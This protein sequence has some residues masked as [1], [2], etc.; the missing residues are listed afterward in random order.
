MPV[1]VGLWQMAG[2]LGLACLLGGLLGLERDVKGHEAGLRTH[3]LL[4]LGS[5]MFALVSVASFGDFIDADA[6]TVQVDPSRIASYVAAGVGF[7]GG[8]AILKHGGNVTGLTTAASLWVAAAIGV[9]TGLGMWPAAL[10]GAGLRTGV[11]GDPP[12]DLA[13]VRTAT[14]PPRGRLT[15]PTGVGRRRRRRRPGPPSAVG[16]GRRPAD[17]GPSLRRRVPA[18]RSAVS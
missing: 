11:V 6:S 4:S 3:M 16:V 13:C 15:R 17:R 14:D 12:S 18:G 10:L 5:A 8:G 1:D 9:A 2:R 7:I